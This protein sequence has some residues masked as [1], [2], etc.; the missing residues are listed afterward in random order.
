MIYTVQHQVQANASIS[1]FQRIWGEW[2]T[3]IM[4]TERVLSQTTH[5]PQLTLSNPLRP[6]CERQINFSR[7]CLTLAVYAPETTSNAF[8]RSTHK[9]ISTLTREVKVMHRGHRAEFVNKHIQFIFFCLNSTW[10]KVSTGLCYSSILYP[11]KHLE[12][13]EASSRWDAPPLKSHWN[14]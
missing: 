1:R 8:L 13:T 12:N 6:S 5:S 10:P 4:L 3:S 11:T 7:C 2:K 9:S 14:D